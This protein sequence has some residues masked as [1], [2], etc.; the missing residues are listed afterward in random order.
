M[1]AMTYGTLPTRAEFDEAFERECPDGYHMQLGETDSRAVDGFRLGDGTLTADQL[2]AGVTEIVAYLPAGMSDDD[3]A[4]LAKQ[5]A[6]MDLV[7]GIM[8]SL[9]F[10]WV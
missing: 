10:E 6:A 7:S 5:D 2:W 1:T 4:E 3:P 9:G 8:A